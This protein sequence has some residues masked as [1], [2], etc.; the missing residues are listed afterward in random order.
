MSTKIEWTDTTV[1]PL[2]GCRKVSPGCQNCYAEKMARRLKAIGVPA[3]QDVVDE[4]DWTGTVGCNRDAMQVSGRGKM[5]FVNSMGDL[6]YEGVTDE[7]RAAVFTMMYLQAHKEHVWQV[8][9]KRPQAAFD[10]WCK[11]RD[12][13]A[14]MGNSLKLLGLDGMWARLALAGGMMTDS[15]GHP[16]YKLPPNL[17]L[18]TTCEN[19][20]WADRRIPILLQIPAAVRFVSLEPLLSKINL[21]LRSDGEVICR[22]CCN[23]VH[24]VNPT[25][26]HRSECMVCGGT[27]SLGRI[28]WVIVGCE[29]GPGR[30]PCDNIWVTGIVDQCLGAGVPVFVK[31][32]EINGKVVKNIDQISD[33]IGRSPEDLRQ[34]PKSRP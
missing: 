15:V 5:V 6:F 30:R 31:Q 23:N 27:G 10:W 4:H 32:I 25:H 24:C 11:L 34:W 21:W 18:G 8:L 26:R 13:K 19:Q 33:R 2:P 1:N 17:W 9:S 14:G 7:Q 12:G 28:D 3:Y 16:P 29:S 20:E 22:Q